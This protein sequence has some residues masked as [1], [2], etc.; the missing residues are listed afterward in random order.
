LNLLSAQQYNNLVN[1]PVFAISVS[2]LYEYALLP[3]HLTSINPHVKATTIADSGALSVSSGQ[4]TGRTPK[5]KRV[6]LDETTKD[7]RN[8]I[9]IDIQI[10]KSGGVVSTFLSLLKD[11]LAIEAEPL[12][13]SI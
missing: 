10:R 9:I 8:A 4:K 12:I 11:M 13:S 7:V 5:E 2:E 3:E 6:V 1:L